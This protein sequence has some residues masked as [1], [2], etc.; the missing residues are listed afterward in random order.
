[1][2][3][4]R[5]IP[6]E[7][8]PW[9]PTIDGEKCVGCR[10]CLE[11][12]KNDVFVFDEARQKSTVAHPYNCVVECRTCARLCPAEAITFPDAAEFSAFIKQKLS[13]KEM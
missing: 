2:N 7:E 6:R 4:W 12:C 10:E 11:T 8:I 13:S 9:F 1:M 3:A 5:G